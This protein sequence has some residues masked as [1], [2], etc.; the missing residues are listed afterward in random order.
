MSTEAGFLQAIRAAP[1]DV[2]ARLIYADWLEDR[3]DLRAEFLR[4][5]CDLRPLPPDHPNRPTAEQALSRLRGGLDPSW[6][7]VVEPERL[8]PAGQEA[9]LRPSC[10]C[11]AGYYEGGKPRRKPTDF[12]TDVQDTDC[13]AWKRL[14]DLIDRA[15]AE[16]RGRFE[17]GEDVPWP[18]RHH[19]VTLPPSIGR[20]KTVR[21]VMLYGSHLT[22]IPPEVGQMSALASFDVYTS[23]RLHWFPYELAR[24]P[25]LRDSRVSTRA[26]YGNYKLRPPFP[27]L[28]PYNLP[29]SNRFA[30]PALRQC[31]VCDRTFD[32]VGDYRVWLS[33]NV[34]TD[35]MPLLVNACSW[36]CL[37]ALPTPP[38]GYVSKPHRGGPNVQQPPTR[39]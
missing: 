1:N 20:L 9:P 10:D 12:H 34:A 3:G 16:G 36:Q 24:C 29:P 4:V 6:L 31:S 21:E 25:N 13:D 11:Y 35:V 32:D 7:A 22:R 2:E 27:Q 8:R 23:Y 17:F 37:R 26:I 18:E 5:H 38:E 19:I 28:G 15:E 14:L 39:F 30:S 33:L